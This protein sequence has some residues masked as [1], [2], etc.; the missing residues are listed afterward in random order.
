MNIQ[1]LFDLKDSL[2]NI[3]YI[4]INFK[5]SSANFYRRYISFSIKSRIF[6]KKICKDFLSVNFNRIDFINPEK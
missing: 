6:N 1:K 2:E 3:P 5:F 4:A